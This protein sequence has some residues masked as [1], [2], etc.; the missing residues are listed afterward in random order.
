MANI[1]GRE[2]EK[3]QLQELVNS[4]QPEF[5]AIYGRRRVGK[6]FLVREYFNDNFAFF[7]SGTLQ[8]DAEEQKKVFRRA[9]HEYGSEQ[10]GSNDWLDLFFALEDLLKPKVNTGEKCIIF[11]DELPCFDT[12]RSGFLNALDHFWNAWASRYSN[13]KLFVC[14]SATSW[15]INKLINNHGG[16]H[17]RLTAHIYLRP[18]TLSE[19]EQYLQSKDIH[20]EREM[21]VEAYMALGGIPY[22]LNMLHKDESFAQTIDRIYFAPNAPLQLEFN[23]LFASLFRSPEPYIEIIRVLSRHKQGLTRDE[24]SAA[25]HTTTSGRLSAILQ[26]LVYCDFIRPYFVRN[27]S[28]VSKRECIYAL[29]DM[30]SLFH[31]H[32]A[33]KAMTNPTFWTDKAES[34]VIKAWQGLAFEQVVM[35]H[36]PQLKISLGISGMAVEYYSWRSKNTEPKSQ[37]DLILDRADRIVN[38]CEIKYS[39]E[40]YLIDKDEAQKL[41]LRTQNFLYETGSHQT[42]HLTFIT[43]YGLRQNQ[44]SLSVVKSLTLDDL[45]K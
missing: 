34:P 42:T 44:Y 2:Q 38:I 17:N 11:I 3:R 15:M 26:D 35:H 21:I 5:V 22:Y 18:F 32:F 30:F 16:L 45:F 12:N 37:I 6:T 14:G 1:F 29:T 39:H 9:L 10:S 41:K 23:R 8:G 40:Q 24:I 28:K 19:T 33:D 27:R 13:V 4:G 31:L 25:L 7:V 43:P 20:L 36:V